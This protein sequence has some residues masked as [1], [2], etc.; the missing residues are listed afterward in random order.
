VTV[1]EGAGLLAALVLLGVAAF[2]VAAAAGAPVGRY[3]QGGRHDGVLPRTNRIVA[4]VSVVLLAGMA[5]VVAGH[6]GRG[7]FAD[8]PSA[9][10]WI[11][12]AYLAVGVLANLASRSPRERAVFAPVSAVALVLA[13]VAA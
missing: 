9:L 4:A 5:A 2:Q 10:W 1:D 11:T 13:V 12:V 7:P 8:P 3:T 6:A